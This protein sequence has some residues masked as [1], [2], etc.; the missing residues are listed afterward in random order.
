VA[1][2]AYMVVAVVVLAEHSAMTPVTAA[3]EHTASW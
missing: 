1:T 3:M 2:V